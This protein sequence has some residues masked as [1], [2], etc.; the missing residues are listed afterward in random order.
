M[1]QG[2]PD[3]GSQ[4]VCDWARQGED[5]RQGCHSAETNKCYY[6]QCVQ[7]H[8]LTASYMKIVH[9]RH[10]S[11][12]Q[13]L[14]CRYRVWCA[15]GRYGSCG[16]GVTAAQVWSKRSSAS[17][18]QHGLKHGCYLRLSLCFSGCLQVSSSAVMHAEGPRLVGPTW[19]SVSCSASL[20]AGTLA[21]GM[22]VHSTS[23]QRQ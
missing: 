9:S 19:P 21:E 22:G 23:V 15:C 2:Q 8:S 13:C 10:S 1:A 7:R 16:G 12:L 18:P 20:A 5:G 14:H 11:C 4:Q 3:L 17:P 6:R